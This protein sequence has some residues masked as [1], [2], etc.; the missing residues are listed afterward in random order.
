MSK[1][2]QAINHA[3]ERGEF[4]HLSVISKDSGFSATFASASS[5]GGYSTGEAADPIVALVRAI[6]AAPLARKAPKII[7]E[8][9]AAL[10]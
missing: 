2:E 10:S 6:T 3:I 4:V 1:L 8:D 9:D 5:A 7:S